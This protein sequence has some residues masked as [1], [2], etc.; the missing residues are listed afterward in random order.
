MTNPT[1]QPSQDSTYVPPTPLRCFVGASISG[2]I[3]T[4]LYFLT[5]SIATT[6]ANKPL[7]S[8]NATALNIAVAVRTLVVGMSTLGTA[9]FAIATLG[10]V[11]LGIQLLFKPS[12]AE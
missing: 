7:P 11:A 5:I 3:A 8:G 9:I 12:Q 4:A 10:L 1:P 2:A 6:F